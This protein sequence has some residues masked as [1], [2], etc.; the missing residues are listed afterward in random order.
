[1]A[2]EQKTSPKKPKFNAWW[3]YAVVI[4]LL[5][6][7]QFIS[8][9]FSNTKKTTTSELQSFLKNGDIDRIIIISNT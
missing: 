8:S 6:A 3:V 5:I 4:T 9:G 2:K 7:V 1:M